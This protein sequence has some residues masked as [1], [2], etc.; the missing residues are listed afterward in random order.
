[1]LKFAL[2][3]LTNQAKIDDFHIF[4]N[5]SAGIYSSVLSNIPFERG[6]NWLY[7][8]NKMFSIHSIKFFFLNA[9]M[10][11]LHNL[12]K[13]IQDGSHLVQNK[14]S[15]QGMLKMNLLLYFQSNCKPDFPE[16]KQIHNFL[17]IFFNIYSY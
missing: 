10:K 17:H 4:I 8:K 3:L 12:C 1:M 13:K 7:K 15:L 9:N 6:I 11:N 14:V 2:T 16:K 5:I